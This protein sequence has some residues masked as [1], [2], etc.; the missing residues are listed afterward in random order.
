MMF[1]TSPAACDEVRRRLSDSPHRLSAE[2]TSSFWERGVLGPLPCHS[3]QLVGLLQELEQ[4]APS[5]GA[6]GRR[7]VYDPQQSLERIHALARD[8]S[9]V[10]PVAQLL[11]CDDLSFFQARFRVKAP[12]GHDPQPWHQDVG[13]HHGGLFNDGTPIPS[14][15]V[16]LSLDGAD[17]ASGGVVVLPGTHRALL[18]HWQAGFSGLKDLQHSLDTSRAH[19][20]VTPPGH[21][22]IFHSWAVHCS[23]TNASQRPRSALILRYMDRRHALD[24]RFPHYPCSTAVGKLSHH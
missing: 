23:L 14:L 22:Q 11:G 20:L 4:A 18:G 15:T 12:G 3:P 7:N 24:V 16:W 6:T 17:A 5:S 8:P 9:I 19:V 13:Q 1:T 2:A 21:F 10:H